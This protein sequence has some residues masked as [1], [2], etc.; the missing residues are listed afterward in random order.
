MCSSPSEYTHPGWVHS[1]RTSPSNRLNC[2]RAPW[3]CQVKVTLY[4][5][6]KNSTYVVDKLSPLMKREVLGGLLLE[7]EDIALNFFTSF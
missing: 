4:T 5:C 1:V 3:V 7:R 2:Q 6:T